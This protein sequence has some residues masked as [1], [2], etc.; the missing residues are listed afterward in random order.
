MRQIKTFSD[1]RLDGM[2]SYCGNYPDTRDHVPSKIFLD[3]PYP[4]NLPVVPCCDQC[5]QSFSLDEEYIACF[6][7]C[8]LCGSTEIDKLKKVKIKRILLSKEPLRQR[9]KKSQIKSEDEIVFKV[10]TRRLENVLV[11]LA[12]GH[13]KYE[14]SEPVLEEPK[15]IMY[16]PLITMEQNEIDLFFADAE[17]LKLPEVGSRA[18]QNLVIENNIGFSHWTVVQ[19]DN[20]SYCVTMNFG[21]LSVRILIWDYIAAEIVWEE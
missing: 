8:V 9:I 7:E 15:K 18:M 17:L 20:Y 4:E 6:L 3:E 16:S 10:D 5:N 2:C 11:K 1:T 12:K 21:R 13:A 19:P 14:N